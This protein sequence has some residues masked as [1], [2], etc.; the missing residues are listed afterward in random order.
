M[1]L[2]SRTPEGTLIRLDGHPDFESETVTE[3]R[4]RLMR[5]ACELPPRD[6]LDVLRHVEAVYRAAQRR[7]APR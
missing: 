1:I 2:H 6:V 5:L 7:G 3:A 4:G